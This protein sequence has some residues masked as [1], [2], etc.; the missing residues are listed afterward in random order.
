MIAKG[1]TEDVIP[2]KMTS[3]KI[4]VTSRQLKGMAAIRGTTT[5]TVRIQ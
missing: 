2:A 4:R 3:R 1:H 5:R